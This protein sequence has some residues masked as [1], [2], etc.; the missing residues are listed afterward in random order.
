MKKLKVL[1]SAYALNPSGSLQLHPGEDIVGWRLVEQLS[2]FHDVW[3]ITHSY[4]KKAVDEAQAGGELE[5]IKVIF[6]QLPFNLR[7]IIYKFEIGQRFYYYTWQFL[8]WRT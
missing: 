5:D 7:K 3:V 2:R 1:A 4:N 6:I 8:A